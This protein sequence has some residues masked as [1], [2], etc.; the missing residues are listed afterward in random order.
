MSHLST[1]IDEYDI[2]RAVLGTAAVNDRAFTTEAL[3]N[4]NEKIAIGI[5]ARSGEVSVSGWTKGSGIKA[6]EL[7]FK[8]A[9]AGAK[10]IIFT[11]IARDGMLTGPAIESTSELVKLT[12]IDIIASGG[13]GSYADIEAVRSSGAAGVIVGKAIYEG[14]VK[15]EQCWPRE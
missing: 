1:L 14:K 9:E 10:T 7:A 3:N 15:L 11:D 5:D 13:I 6:S 4:Y 8:M 12:G 2:D